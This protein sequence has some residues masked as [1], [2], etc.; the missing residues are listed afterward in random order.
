MC[1]SVVCLGSRCASSFIQQAL[2]RGATSWPPTTAHSIW[3]SQMHQKDAADHSLAECSLQLQVR[4]AGPRIIAALGHNRWVSRY[5]Y[6][7]LRATTI[8]GP[9]VLTC[10]STGSAPS[11]E[12]SHDTKCY[13]H[14]AQEKGANVRTCTAT[15]SRS[16]SSFLLC[17]CSFPMAHIMRPAS[18]ARTRQESQ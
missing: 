16:L 6:N 1:P 10:S 18:G 2:A 12:I 4:T 17:H 7:N 14:A 5:C 11:D 3:L 9:T 15:A 13:K 8:S